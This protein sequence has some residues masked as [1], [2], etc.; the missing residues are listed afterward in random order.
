MQ[1]PENDIQ[2]QQ[3]Q[4]HITIIMDDDALLPTRGKLDADLT[5]ELEELLE[6]AYTTP[7]IGSSLMDNSNPFTKALLLRRPN[8]YFLTHQFVGKRQIVA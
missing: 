8:Q 7:T 6:M 5:F 2:Q 4:Q 1:K 3:Q